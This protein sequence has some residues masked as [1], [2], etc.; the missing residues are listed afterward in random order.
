MPYG[1]DPHR[2]L[3]SGGVRDLLDLV[4]DAELTDE[5]VEAINEAIDDWVEEDPEGYDEQA[6]EDLDQSVIEILERE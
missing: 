5:K 3:A 2:Y 4:P 1:I 6:A